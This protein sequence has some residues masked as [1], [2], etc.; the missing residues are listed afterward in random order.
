MCLARQCDRGIASTAPLF[1]SSRI[2]RNIRLDDVEREQT[3][4]RAGH[5][6]S[7]SYQNQ[8]KHLAVVSYDRYAADRTIGSSYPA[9]NFG[10]LYGRRLYW[11]EYQHHALWIYIFSNKETQVSR[12]S[13][14][15][16]LET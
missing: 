15:N 3:R 7:H 8:K 9:V 4:T 10:D 14:A 5:P 11:I 6:S 12:M 13:A 1:F 16:L 2:G